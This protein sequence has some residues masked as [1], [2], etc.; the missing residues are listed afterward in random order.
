MGKIKKQGAQGKSV[1]KLI[2]SKPM[3]QNEI[4]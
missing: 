3:D 4:R 1:K 2:V